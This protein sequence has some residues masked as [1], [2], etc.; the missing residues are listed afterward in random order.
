MKDFS[1]NLI[2]K[3]RKKYN[4]HIN[5]HINSICNR[6][7]VYCFARNEFK[8][9]IFMTIEEIRDI[10]EKLNKLDK[11]NLIS[12]IGGEPFLHQ[13]FKEILKLKSK[14]DIH[15][16]T[17]GTIN[18]KPY[19]SLLKNKFIT[20]S[21]HYNIENYF[22]TFLENL[23]QAEKNNLNYQFNFVFFNCNDKEYLAKFDKIL[24]FIPKEKIIIS[25]VHDYFD[26][27]NLYFEKYLNFLKEKKFYDQF[28]SN[29][30]LK[31]KKIKYCLY[32]EI[33]IRKEDCIFF[34][35]ADCTLPYL[36]KKEF[37]N[38]YLELNKF[39]KEK[40]CNKNCKNDFAYYGSIIR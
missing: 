21:L 17:N 14:H 36:N 9:N 16:Y 18:I 20:F 22:N 12:L 3:I 38:Y 34:E 19:I 11:K 25:P 30:K 26:D 7:C 32:N 24:E 39:K 4:L 8:W 37:N 27:Y 40:I 31:N 23:K 29:Y 28:I 2:K 13:N 1:F 5:L 6:K 10:Y 15:I 33:N 35:T